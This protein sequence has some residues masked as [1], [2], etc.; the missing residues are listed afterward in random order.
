MTFGT[1]ARPPWMQIGR[2]RV[3]S[4][5]PFHRCTAAGGAQRRSPTG[6]LAYGTPR[7]TSPDASSAW[8]DAKTAS[9]CASVGATGCLSTSL[10]FED[11]SRTS[12]PA[13]HGFNRAIEGR[14]HRRGGSVADGYG[15]AD[16]TEFGCLGRWLSDTAIRTR[17]HC[18]HCDIRR[19]VS[20]ETYSARRAVQGA[21]VAFWS[22]DND[23]AMAHP[24]GLPYSASG[25]SA[26]ASDLV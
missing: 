17:A 13:S 15:V 22:L 24:S 21:P 1:G 10:P 14:H 19:L 2:G 25:P 18:S 20:A 3:A 4:R 6:G 7:L 12:R 26:T 23:V 9:M 16:A 5:V 8:S 11:L